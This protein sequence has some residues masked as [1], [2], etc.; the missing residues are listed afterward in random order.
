MV[1][2][3]ITLGP[4]HSASSISLVNCLVGLVY[5][6]ERPSPSGHDNQHNDIH[7]NDTQSND[8][9]I[10]TFRL[11]TLSKMTIIVMTEL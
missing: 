1:K 5:K 6:D 10:I 3:F 11:T 8:I 2:S 4:G 7:N 9:R